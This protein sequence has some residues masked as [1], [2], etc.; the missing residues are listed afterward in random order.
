MKR[1]SKRAMVLGAGGGLVL[2]ALVL[3]GMFFP[4]NRG[5]LART[6]C[7]VTAHA[8]Y[9]LPVGGDTL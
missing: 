8:R 1:M 3:V 4:W 6:V 5:R 9:E 2:I 7:R